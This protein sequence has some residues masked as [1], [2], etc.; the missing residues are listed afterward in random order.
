[1]N[2]DGA[3]KTWSKISV[4]VDGVEVTGSYRIGAKDLMTVK[5]DGG[6][7]KSAQGGPAAES[8]ARVILH[9]LA[10]EKSSEL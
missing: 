7:S 3:S 5:M 10:R 1:M 8:V 4:V 6:G 2:D 9:E